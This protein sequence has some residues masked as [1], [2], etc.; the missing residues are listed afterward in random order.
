MPVIPGKK[1]LPGLKRLE[2]DFTEKVSLGKKITGKKR[3][4][5]LLGKKLERNAEKN[6][7]TRQK[8]GTPGEKHLMGE[9]GRFGRKAQRWEGLSESDDEASH[10]NKKMGGNAYLYF[11]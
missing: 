1:L 9:V 3:A 7:L 10:N 11:P 4:E 2:R 5:D 6:A 8:R